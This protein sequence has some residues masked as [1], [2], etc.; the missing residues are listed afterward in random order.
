EFVR[1]LQKYHVAMTPPSRPICSLLFLG[2]T[3]VGKTHSV[4][5]LAEALLGHRDHL[6][7]ID[8]AEF[9]H[10]H[11]VSKLMGSPPAYLGH[12]ES[13]PRL[14]QENID[15]WSVSKVKAENGEVL[16]NS[17]EK[18]PSI[19]LFDEIEKAHEDFFDLLLGILDTGKLA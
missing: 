1:A 6:T 13:K 10:S 11:E 12:R 15:K 19:L 5:A 18:K 3:R 16:G 8:C 2:P 4:H 9:N 14:S 7:R 17:L